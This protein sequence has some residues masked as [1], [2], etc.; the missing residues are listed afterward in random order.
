MI[1]K[2]EIGTDLRILLGCYEGPEGA[3][4]VFCFDD[5]PK[6]V[7]V[8]VKHAKVVHI[9]TTLAGLAGMPARGTYDG[10][11]VNTQDGPEAVMGKEWKENAIAE[12]RKLF[13]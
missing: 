11:I 8:F 1:E 3:T 5:F 12:T 13:Q 7:L 6:G 4:A 10:V 9:A 2:F